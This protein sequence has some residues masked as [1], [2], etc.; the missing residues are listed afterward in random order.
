LGV[1]YTCNGDRL[2]LES[3]NIRDLSDTSTFY[4]DA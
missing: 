4:I 1:T 3:C 2:Y